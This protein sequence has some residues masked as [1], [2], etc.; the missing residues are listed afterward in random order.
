MKPD[1]PFEEA[2]AVARGTYNCVKLV[3][4]Y[5]IAKKYYGDLTLI[6]A[7]NSS[8]LP[9]LTADYGINEVCRNFQHFNT[10]SLSSELFHVEMKCW[11]DLNKWCYL[12]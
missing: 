2:K 3:I 5:R 1:V 11:F 9:G 12:K 10:F 7:E 6:K 8:R 4:N